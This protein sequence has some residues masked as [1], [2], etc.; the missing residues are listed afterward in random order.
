M[1]LYRGAAGVRTWSKYQETVKEW[2]L[3]GI[4]PTACN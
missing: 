1:H 3:C 4:A 2:A